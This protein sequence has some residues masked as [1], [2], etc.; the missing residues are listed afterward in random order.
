[1]SSRGVSMASSNGGDANP[2]G[3]IQSGISFPA[4]FGMAKLILRASPHLTS[5]K[6]GNVLPNQRVV[7][8]QKC[9][10]EDGT[11][12]AK[13]G[14]VSE[15]RGVIVDVLGWVTMANGKDEQLR[16]LTPAEQHDVDWRLRM[17][18]D[19][20]RKDLDIFAAR[21]SVSTS[22]LV[23]G[24]AHGSLGSMASRIAERRRTRLTS[25]TQGWG[26]RK[27]LSYTEQGELLK[28]ELIASGVLSARPPPESLLSYPS[29]E[30]QH[31][32]ATMLLTNKG[33]SR[34]APPYPKG[35]FT[36]PAEEEAAWMDPPSL[37]T[38]AEKHYA[39][40]RAVESR[41]FDTFPKR[42]GMIVLYNNL[43]PSDIEALVKKTDVDGDRLDKAEFRQ[44]LRALGGGATWPPSAPPSV[45]SEEKLDRRLLCRS[46]LSGETT[47]LVGKGCSDTQMHTYFATLDTDKSG[48]LDVKE[49]SRQ[50]LQLKEAITRKTYADAVAKVTG[51][52][53]AS[54]AFEKAA[55]L[56]TAVAS[57]P[58]AQGPT[59]SARLGKL[60]QEKAVKIDSLR[61]GWDP[62]GSGKIDKE[63]FQKALAGLGFECTA[64]E[65]EQLFIEFDQDSGKTLSVKELVASMKKLQQDARDQAAAEANAAG[66]A[67]DAVGAAE[68]SVRHAFKLAAA[69]AAF[70]L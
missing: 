41:F 64:E 28:P 9:T 52:R 55:V 25:R 43:G 29:L 30:R 60:L 24:P 2:F 38:I 51:L 1:M 57:V 31:G 17:D 58:V 62:D 18:Q 19:N 33:E 16:C 8:M 44:M 47:A 37:L 65:V 21:E 36:G 35:A 14:K 12:R 59:V 15:P 4:A 56:V 63:E 49:V 10:L 5:E 20:L 54:E 32:K 34:Q 6:L 42:V 39:Y 48:S 40:S 66:A 26:S 3:M 13:V 23:R 22:L 53:Q 27:W 68:N 11:V 7:V 67:S 61:T 50:L 46:W 69:Q 70:E 45:S